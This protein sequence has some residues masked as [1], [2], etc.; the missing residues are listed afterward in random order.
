M[1]SWACYNTGESPGLRP[2]EHRIGGG[3]GTGW[4]A[5]PWLSCSSFLDNLQQLLGQSRDKRNSEGTDPSLPH[6]SQGPP[7]GRE[8]LWSVQTRT[9]R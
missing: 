3:G 6:G 1:N 9:P 5:S 4:A 8:G 7:P 2:K